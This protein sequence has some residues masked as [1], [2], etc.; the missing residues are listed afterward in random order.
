MLLTKSSRFYIITKI[1]RT[2]FAR[3]TT[4]QVALFYMPHFCCMI[5][6]KLYKSI[7]Y[8][9]L[10]S[11]HPITSIIFLL[12]LSTRN[13]KNGAR[14]VYCQIFVRSGVRASSH[15]IVKAGII[16]S[17]CIWRDGVI[18]VVSALLWLTRVQFLVRPSLSVM[19]LYEASSRFRVISTSNNNKVIK[20]GT[21]ISLY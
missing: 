6:P 19:T 12:F 15:L 11:L 21:S 17:R 18:L 5:C 7:L 20:K 10:Y 1:S 16:A 2:Y 14:F 13:G 4:L 9:V 3:G 8:H